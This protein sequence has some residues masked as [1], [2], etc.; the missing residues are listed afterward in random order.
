MYH[1]KSKNEKTKDM[2]VGKV[3]RFR[4]QGSKFWVKSIEHRAERMGHRG[5]Q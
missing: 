4:V 1:F 3:Q 5:K 2:N